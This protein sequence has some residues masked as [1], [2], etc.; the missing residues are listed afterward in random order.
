MISTVQPTTEPARL[1]LCEAIKPVRTLEGARHGPGSRF[2][3]P[4]DWA[5]TRAALG[6]IKVVGGTRYTKPP[7]GDDSFEPKPPKTLLELEGPPV[8][9]QS[10]CQNGRLGDDHVAYGEEA[11]LRSEKV[12]IDLASIDKCSIVGQLSP[13]GLAYQGAVESLKGKPLPAHS[14]PQY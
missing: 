1:V 8:L 11:M 3:A 13:R 14:W 9:V 6:A 5:A 2:N 12:A 7:S 4:E 10:R